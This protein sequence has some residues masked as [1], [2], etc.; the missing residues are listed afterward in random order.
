MPVPQS[1]SSLSDI[2]GKVRRLTNSPSQSQ[3]SD[4]NLNEYINTF[5][6]QDFAYAIKVDQMRN[7]YTFYTQPNID[8][9][10]LD[11][12]F[13][14]GVRSPV[15][16]DG[17]Q[18]SF[19]KDRIQFY[20]LWPRIATKFQQGAETLSGTITG[21]AQPT[22]PTQVTSPNHGLTNGAVIFI[23]GILGMIQLNNDFYTITRIDAN[24]FS[25]NG[26]DNTAFGAYIS[27]G[28]WTA[29]NQTFA[30]TLPGPFLSKEITI[31]G[32]STNGNQ[33]VINDDGDG[34]L[35][36]EVPNP[37]TS[38]PTKN[39]NPA[40]AGMYNTNLN[41]PGLNNPFVIGGVDYVSGTFNFTLPSG[42]SLGSGKLFNIFISQY[43]TGRPYNLLF[44]NNEFTV[45]P[46]PKLTHKIEIET[47]LTPVQFMEDS[48]HPII[49]QWW[50]YIAYGVACEIQRE[51]GDFASVDA[52][53]EGMKR[54]E[55]LVLERQGV[56]EI[57]QPNYTLFN[58]TVP[59]PTL[60]NFWGQGT[61]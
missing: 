22:D 57:G 12:N 14:Q 37:V 44:W 1:G 4:N 48:D 36:I 9:Y 11:I 38:T 19:Y 8:R 30:F 58:S 33:I 54:Q 25:L 3:L 43:Q 18:G 47:Y 17:I 45:R 10:P 51:R 23:T 13:N 5:Y 40:I 21:I 52:L 61:F 32:V 34:T 24:T 42:T 60:N 46:V 7:V 35:L 55:A 53:M 29:N 39:E 20:N 26:I 49:N 6:N 31:G 59:D 27:G 2:R 28:T 56:E 15:Y 50:Q 16:I 41:N